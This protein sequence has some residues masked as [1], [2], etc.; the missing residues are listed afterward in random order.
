[1]R[2]VQPDWRAIYSNGTLLHF[3]HP[4]Y[5]AKNE[6]LSFQI[7]RWD[8]ESEACRFSYK[9]GQLLKALCCPT[10]T[11]RTIFLMHSEITS[12]VLPDLISP[13]P[14]PLRISRHHKQVTRETKAWLFKD[15]NLLG[16]KAEA[17]HGLKSGTL[18]AMSYPNAAYPQLRVCCDF[19]TY[20]F[21]L[22]NLSDDMDERRTETI[23]DAVLNT[24]YHPTTYS[25][26]SRIAKMTKEYVLFLTHVPSLTMHLSYWSRLIRTASPGTQQRFIETFDFFFQSVTEQAVARRTGTILTLEAYIELRRDT[27]GEYIC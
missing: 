26:S 23:A 22:D 2:D 16:Q 4:L 17:Y 1:M 27:S 9:L 15:G 6:C 25:S 14:F 12:F 7:G 3:L 20:L 21:H 19:L 18:T 5:S 11:Q 8:L 13:C 24:L 10:A